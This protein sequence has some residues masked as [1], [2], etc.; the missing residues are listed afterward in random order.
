MSDES[1]NIIVP[2]RFTAAPS[3]AEIVREWDAL[4][5]YL[6][7]QPLMEV[8]DVPLQQISLPITVY[9]RTRNPVHVSVNAWGER[10][11][12]PAAVSGIHWYRANTPAPPGR[13]SIVV[14]TLSGIDLEASRYRLSLAVWGSHELLG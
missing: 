12:V 8:M 3:A 14:T 6:R 5:D 7:S 2:R 9:V 13:T 1:R 4:I 11:E 10:S